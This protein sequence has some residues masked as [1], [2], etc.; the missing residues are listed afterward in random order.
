MRAR[1]HTHTQCH[2]AFCSRSI[3]GFAPENSPRHDMTQW[4][5]HS[6][7]CA[8]AHSTHCAFIDLKLPWVAKF[9][10]TLDVIDIH[11]GPRIIFLC[12]IFCPLSYFE[13]KQSRLIRSRCCPCVCVC[14]P[15]IVA[16]ERVGKSPLIV[17]RQRLCKN[18][19]IVARQSFGKN[20]L[21]V[22]R[23]RLGKN[24]RIV[25]QQRLGRSPLIDTRQWLGKN[26]PII[27]RQRLGK[28]PPIIARQ[29]LSRN[30]TAVTNTHA[31]IEELLDVS[32]SMWPM[33]YQ[34][35]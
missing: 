24:H 15:T 5:V 20:P 31:T 3:T 27:A 7:E 8:Q 28:N 16:R 35:K 4:E 13:K 26:H 33:L 11:E 21:I 18:P 2:Q 17:A 6:N 1:T 19:P 23:K 30:V 34:G 12:R 10:H 9:S 25:A 14:I 32:F 22:A 29:W